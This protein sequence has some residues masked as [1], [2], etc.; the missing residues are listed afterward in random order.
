MTNSEVLEIERSSLSLEIKC[1][2]EFFKKAAI[3]L[4]GAISDA[5]VLSPMCWKADDE[6]IM[7]EAP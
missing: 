2:R 3:N 4:A 5:T 6:A 1:R 7:N